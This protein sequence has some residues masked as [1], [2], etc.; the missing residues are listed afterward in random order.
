MVNAG[1]FYN[2]EDALKDK[3]IM[4]KY[5]DAIHRLNDGIITPKGIYAIPSEVSPHRHRMFPVRD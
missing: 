5:G 2:M 1:L 3:D 4:E